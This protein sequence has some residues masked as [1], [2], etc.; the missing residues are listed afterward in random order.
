MSRRRQQTASG[1]ERL[2]DLSGVTGGGTLKGRAEQERPYLAAWSGKD[3]AYK[4]GRLKACGARRESEGFVV[5]VK[6]CNKRAGG[7][8]PCFDRARAEVSAR[9]C[10]K[11]PTTPRDKVRELQRK[12]WGVPSRARHGGS[13]RCMTG[14]TGVTSCGK[15]GGGCAV[16]AARRASIPRRSRHRAVGVEKFLAEIRRCCG[17][18]NTARK[19]CG[20]GTY[21]KRMESSGHWG[22]RRCGTG[23]CRWR[24]SW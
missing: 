9:A 23:W 8:G 2:L 24:R 12:L 20:G 11:R 7:K 5:P 1:P 4:A 22:Y 6:A 15:H 14:S 21:R 10:R 13:M 17:Q 16:T 3:R 18:A 19:R